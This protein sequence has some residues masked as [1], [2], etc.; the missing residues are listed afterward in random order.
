VA[1]IPYAE[2]IKETIAWFE[3]DPKRM[4]INPVTNKLLDGL[5]KKW[6]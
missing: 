4:I 6:G 2:G 1:T 3:A 5:V